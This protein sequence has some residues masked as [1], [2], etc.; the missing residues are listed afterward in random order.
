[1]SNS[2]KSK[3]L[4]I[5]TLLFMQAPVWGA[6]DPPEVFPL[7]SANYKDSLLHLMGTLATIFATLDRRG[8]L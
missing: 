2:F 8:P 7:D 3:Y 5:G 1:M 4:K 6:S